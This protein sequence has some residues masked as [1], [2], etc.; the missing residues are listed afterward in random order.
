MLLYTANILV[1]I[2]EPD[3]QISSE[4]EKISFALSKGL[5]D[6]DYLYRWVK[7][8]WLKYF[9]QLLN[10]SFTFPWDEYFYKGF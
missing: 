4:N 10:N 3:L 6:T 1:G 7:Y 9:H 2:K 8:N 5:P